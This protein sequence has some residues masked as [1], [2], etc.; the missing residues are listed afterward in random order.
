MKHG[1]KNRRK[2]LER[3]I[4]LTI[5]FIILSALVI[6]A[7]MYDKISEHQLLNILIYIFCLLGMIVMLILFI[8]GWED[9][10]E[11][12]NDHP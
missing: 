8:S 11:E 3:I 4:I 1:V 7:G 6:I 10:F 2:F 9:I 12:S 5:E